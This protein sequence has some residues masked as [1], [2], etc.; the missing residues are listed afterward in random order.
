MGGNVDDQTLICALAPLGS[1]NAL[2]D[3]LVGTTSSG[4]YTCSLDKDRKS[5]MLDQLLVWGKNVKTFSLPLQYCGRSSRF[6]LAN[7]GLRC[8]SSPLLGFSDV[9]SVNSHH[10]QDDRQ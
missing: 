9:S 2:E 5:K 8:F 1:R 3:G 6:N 4:K 7:V 10:F